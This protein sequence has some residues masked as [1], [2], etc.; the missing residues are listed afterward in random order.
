MD[1]GRSIQR[2]HTGGSQ[3]LIPPVCG[4]PEQ[5]RYE[6]GA[7]GAWDVSR[8]LAETGKGPH[9]ADEAREATPVPPAPAK[10]NCILFSEDDLATRPTDAQIIQPS[11]AVDAHE[12][13]ITANYVAWLIE[14]SP[15]QSTGITF[16][17]KVG[18]LP[19]VVCLQGNDGRDGTSVRRLTGL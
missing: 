13:G 5:S 19:I 7:K 2:M 4:L 9:A 16:L 11:P 14:V 3:R 8:D 17:V 1:A 15:A 6:G 18:P 12:T 10:S